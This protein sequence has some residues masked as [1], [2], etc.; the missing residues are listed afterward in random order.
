MTLDNLFE[1]LHDSLNVYINNEKGTVKLIP[2]HTDI[3]SGSDLISVA[4]SGTSL[5]EAERELCKKLS[6]QTLI[7]PPLHPGGD[8]IE[9][10]TG[11]VVAD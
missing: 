8:P 6:N 3:K 7:R 4:A 5:V 2:R 9:I 11:E 10:T 1:E